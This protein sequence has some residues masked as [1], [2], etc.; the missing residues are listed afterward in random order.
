MDTPLRR[1]LTALGFALFWSSFMVLWSG[2]T[3][4]RQYRHPGNTRRAGR[5]FL[6]LGDGP[7]PAAQ[8]GAR[9]LGDRDLFLSRRRFRLQNVSG[10]RPSSSRTLWLLAPRFNAVA[11]GAFN[12]RGVAAG[13]G[14]MDVQVLRGG[15]GELPFDRLFQEDFLRRSPSRSSCLGDRN[16]APPACAGAAGRARYRAHRRSARPGRT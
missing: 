11:S 2:D 9:Q 1:H 16:R 7:H 5:L 15:I 13:R 10:S 14:E 4:R 3:S 8:S 6:G 12:S